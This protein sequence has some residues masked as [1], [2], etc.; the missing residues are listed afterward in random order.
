MATDTSLSLQA[1]ANRIMQDPSSTTLAD[2][3]SANLSALGGT[4]TYNLGSSSADADGISDARAEVVQQALAYIS[5]TTGIR[6]T[7]VTG[8]SLITFTDDEA[9]AFARYSYWPDTNDMFSA[10]VNISDSW[11]QGSTSS[12][13]YYFQTVLHEIGHA[14][15]LDHPDEY[16]TFTYNPDV[17]ND[18]WH[19]SV[20]SYA[21]LSQYQTEGLSYSQTYSVADLIA[22]QQ[23]YSGQ[24]AQVGAS[25]GYQILSGDTVYGFNTS[26]DQ[27]LFPVLSA[28]ADNAGNNFYTL[29]DA[30]G[31]DTLDASGWSMDQNIDLTIT[32]AS[33]TSATTSSIGGGSGNLFLAAGTVIENATTGAG[34]DRIVGNTAAN[35]LSGGGGEDVLFGGAGNDT[36][37]G[38]DGNDVL[39]GGD[40]NDLLQGGA[41]TEL[42]ILEAGDDT[43]DGGAGI[44]WLTLADRDGVHVNL[45]RG[46]AF[47]QDTGR[48]TI[49][50]IENVSGSS[51]DDYLTGDDNDN[52]LIGND[53]NDRLAGGG[54][55][56]MLL[57]GI[58]ADRLLGDDGND[59]QLG[60]D[61]DDRL[62]IGAGDD[63]LEGGDGVDWVYSNPNGTNVID[64]S[65]TGTQST[66]FGNDTLTEIENIS[67]SRYGDALTGDD[68]ANKLRGNAGDDTL[69]GNGGADNLLGSN[70]ADLLDG[71]AGND[72]LMAGSDNDTLYGQ[73]GDDRLWGGHGDDL[74]DGGAG[75]D[76]FASDAGDDTLIGGD[77]QDW[78]RLN[79]RT[80]MRVDLAA[81]T[82]TGDGTGTDTL[83]GIE[84]VKGF[85]ADDHITGD[86]GSNKLGGGA[87]NDTVF[88]AGGDDTLWGAAGNDSL[89]SGL[90]NDLVYGGRGH[91]S[92]WGGDGDDTLAGGS[93]DDLLVGGLGTDQ[94]TGGKGADIF[95]IMLGDGLLTDV[96]RDFTVGTDQLQFELDEDDETG[97]LFSQSGSG[98]TVTYGT[99]SVYL[100]GVEDEEVQADLLSFG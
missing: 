74:L 75:D 17:A 10:Q 31:I 91:D 87:G 43:I 99:S 67:G 40:G 85:K 24:V 29:A 82:A 76:T 35:H 83:S 48:D 77:G 55:D 89:L 50:G 71:G 58:G 47:D 68:G 81:G 23:L 11:F 45:F 80:D 37:T 19:T 2:P 65:N 8:D 9:G 62:Y 66:G 78:L 88:G 53:G 16:T 27:N 44:D 39:S 46:T 69:Y 28:L 100:D 32:Q 5:N 14:L 38:G 22:L 7:E 42:F 4:I 20:M 63:V 84:N 92:L 60:G 25:T 73:G 54:G 57:G 51:G 70:G 30:G 86:D 52:Q 1:L 56:D 41:G 64:L 3:L 97:L 49:I 33:A 34:D 36:L 12:T 79:G 18:S 13:D 21:A 6:F 61:G 93:G 26:L 95:R 94:L 98:L 90:G 15:G 72:R 59:T 96:I